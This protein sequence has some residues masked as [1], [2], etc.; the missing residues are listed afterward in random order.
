MLWKKFNDQLAFILIVLFILTW[1]ADAALR[2]L[3]KVGL[4]E[5]VMGATVSLITLVVQYY[6][7]RKEPDN[8]VTK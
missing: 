4:S 7:R 6:F 2:Y 1:F 8:G 3:L 5:A